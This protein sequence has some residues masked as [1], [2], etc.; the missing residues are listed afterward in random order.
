MSNAVGASK[1]DHTILIAY[2][3]TRAPIS[4]KLDPAEVAQAYEDL[5][6]LRQTRQDL[7]RR[8]RLDAS[9]LA[10]LDMLTTLPPYY[11]AHLDIANLI[12]GMRVATIEELEDVYSAPSL[13][14]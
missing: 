10:L 5:R 7:E 11:P 3:G 2:A 6:G 9:Q 14:L 8:R 1:E 4:P 12:T 13:G